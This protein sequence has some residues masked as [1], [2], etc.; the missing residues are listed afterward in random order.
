MSSIHT[1]RH[2]ALSMFQSLVD[3]FILDRDHDDTEPLEA[4][5]QERPTLEHPL[6][7]AAAEFV[8][9]KFQGKEVPDEPPEE[10]AQKKGGSTAW[11]CVKLAGEL[12]L[13]CIEGDDER[14]TQLED[15]LKDSTCDPEWVEAILQYLEYFGP[16]GKK[17]TVPYVTWQE[18]DDFVLEA[19]PR[20]AR[21]ALIADWGTGTKDAEDLLRHVADKEP[22]VLIHLGDVYYAGT[23]RETHHNFLDLIDRVFDRA[24][25]PM[26]VYTLTGNHDMYSGG[27]GYYELLPQLNPS[28]PHAPEAAQ[29][30]SFFT[31]RSPDGAWQLQA[32]DTGLNDRDPFTVTTDIT[33]LEPREAQWHLDKIER[34]AAE[35]GKTILLSHHQLFSPFEDIGK[36]ADKP[37]GQE[38]YNPKLLETFQPVLERGL[39]SAW[40]WGHEHNLGIYQPYG[41][42]EKGRCIGHAAIPV[43]ASQTPYEILDDLDDPP[44]LVEV[45]GQPVQLAQNADGVY[46]H[47]YVILALDDSA[48]RAKARYYATPED[49]LV[50][51]EVLK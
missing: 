30:A 22:D 34:F 40:F 49:T 16:G 25:R 14:K 32:M 10:V 42:L 9:R 33:Y 12:F 17:R 11:T 44:R 7:H 21:V 8:E 39:V 24:S 20:N 1:V 36:T 45:D 51:E 5:G 28:P 37:E 13:A 29:P 50:Y 4:R 3:D 46:A 19:L 15:E 41:P 6:V 2:A 43:F 31:L 27:V 26:P 18:P 35:G 47:G 38:A 48:R 23:E